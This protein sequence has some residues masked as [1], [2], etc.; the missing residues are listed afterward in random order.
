MDDHGDWTQVGN[1]N[2]RRRGHNVIL[3]EESLLVVGDATEIPN[4]KCSFE[5]N[6]IVCVD[7]E[8]T[9]ENYFG[10]PELL[11]VPDFFCKN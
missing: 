9:L 10:W 11:L 2:H 7:Q 3:V 6:K 8:L 4:E 1:L 5:N